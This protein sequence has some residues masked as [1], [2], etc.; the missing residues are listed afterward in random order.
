MPVQV[1]GKAIP[2]KL[3]DT[4]LYFLPFRVSH[5]NI[6]FCD[7]KAAVELEEEQASVLK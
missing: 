3:V 4:V 5:P 6:S 7:G 1:R 2:D